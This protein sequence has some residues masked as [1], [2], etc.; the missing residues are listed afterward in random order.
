MHVVCV[1]MSL[2]ECVCVHECVGLC[3]VKP[4]TAALKSRHFMQIQQPSPNTFQYMLNHQRSSQSIHLDV[5][6]CTRLGITGHAWIRY[7]LLCYL[8]KKQCFVEV[9]CDYSLS[10]IHPLCC[11]WFTALLCTVW[12]PQLSYSMDII[13]LY[14]GVQVVTLYLTPSVITRYNAIITMS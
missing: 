9:V 3:A 2:C 7:A 12:F 5:L 6:F 1:F 8:H 10:Y 13:I 14:R 11:H 4:S